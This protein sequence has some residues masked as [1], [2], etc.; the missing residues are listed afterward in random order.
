MT[1]DQK[2]K[3]LDIIAAELA[4]TNGGPLHA[5]GINPVFGEGNP[6]AE[7]LFIGE[8]PGFNE[9]AQGRPFVGV[10]GKLLRKNIAANGWAEDEVYITNI[11]KFRPPENRDPTPSEI[12]YFKPFLDRQIEIIDPKII[13]TLGRYSM[14]K[15][16]GEGVSISRIHGVPRAI[17]WSGKEITVFPMYHPA[18]A[19]R[20]GDVMK[21]FESDFMKLRNILTK[22]ESRTI[23]PKAAEKDTIKKDSTVQLHLV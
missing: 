8:A 16:F 11:V 7:I 4:A 5:L 2:Q 6:D 19:L 23:S 18:A 21:E 22:E 12:E 17:K 1:K 13:I 20:A 9:N 10:S 14:F 3:E 15:F